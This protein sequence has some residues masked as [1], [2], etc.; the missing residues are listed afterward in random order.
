V[1]HLF[2]VFSTFALGGPQARFRDLAHALAGRY[3]HTVLAMDGNVAAG[4]SLDASVQWTEAT[5]PVTKSAGI[6]LANLRHAHRLLRQASPDLLLTYNW[7]AIEWALANWP[8]RRRHIHFEDGFGPDEAAGRHNPRRVLA[9]R[10]LLSR[11]E[12]VVVPSETLLAVARERWRLPAERVL[13]LPNGIDCDRFAGAPDG[14][15]VAALGLA[16]GTLVVGTVAGLRREKNLPR[17]VRLFATL[18]RALDARLVI[19]GDGPERAA[20]LAEATRLGVA[21]QTILAG[22]MAAPERLLGRFDVFVLSSDTEQMPNALLE[23]MA[24]ALPVLATD[25]GDVK[26]LVAPANAA[27][28]LAREDEAGLSGGLARLLQDADLRAQLGRANAAHVRAHFA[29]ATMVA[30]Y[31]ALFRGT[32]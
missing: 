18:P 13:H 30:R 11:C 17:L 25:V 7:G 20:I 6:S 27:F 31:D 14:A 9:R 23:A 28:V 10:L 2:H 1:S 22:P 24:A 4:S 3:R 26:R 8:W 12:R 16:P 21:A 29:L 19:I 5:M 32:A 15:G